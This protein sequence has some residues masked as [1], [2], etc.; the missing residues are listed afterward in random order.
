MT[1]GKKSIYGM[2]FNMSVLTLSPLMVLIG[3]IKHHQSQSIDENE[4]IIPLLSNEQNA[5]TSNRLANRISSDMHFS[6]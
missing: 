4:E 5:D 3:W 6:F 2:L 1:G